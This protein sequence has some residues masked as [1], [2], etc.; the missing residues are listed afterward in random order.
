LLVGGSSCSVRRP[1]ACCCSGP[2]SFWAAATKL[3]LQSA[4]RLSG[5]TLSVLI[6]HNLRAPPSSIHLGQDANETIVKRSAFSDYRVVYFATHGLVAGEVR[7]L[8]EPSLAL[9]LP[10]QASEMDDGLRRAK[11]LKL[12]HPSGSCSPREI[13]VL[14]S[15]WR[16]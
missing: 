10:K 12:K 9:T 1:S 6:A 4:M 11:W 7:G 14:G 13:S 15:C 2:V 5:S 3:R 8:A 16:S